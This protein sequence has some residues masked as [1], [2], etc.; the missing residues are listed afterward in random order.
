[1]DEESIGALV[2]RLRRARRL[3][4]VEL[5]ELA[6]VGRSWLSQVELDRLG[7]PGPERLRRL[8]GPLGVDV[9][10]LLGRADRRS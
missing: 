8:A 10:W 5:A 4:Q 9:A 6:G 7:R 2:R 1:V 3:Q